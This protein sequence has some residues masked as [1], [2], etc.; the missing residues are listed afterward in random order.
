MTAP[1][2]TARVLRSVTMARGE[3][4]AAGNGILSISR[5]NSIG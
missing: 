2:S 4:T 5:R 3:I 1:Q